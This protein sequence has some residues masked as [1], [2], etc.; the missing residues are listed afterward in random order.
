VDDR[1]P[2]DYNLIFLDDQDATTRSSFL[3]ALESSEGIAA[4]A[5]FDES[6]VPVVVDGVEMASSLAL[7]SVASASLADVWRDDDPILLTPGTVVAP[8]WVLDSLAVVDGATVTLELGDT[9]QTVTLVQDN[10]VAAAVTHPETF[11]SADAGRPAMA[12]LRFTDDADRDS[13]ID[14][15]FALADERGIVLQSID[16]SDYRDTLESTL[17][18]MLLV[19]VGLLAVAVVIALIGVSNTLSLSVF[20]RTRESALLRALGFTR[21]QLRRSLAIEGV[22]LAAVGAS[23][24]IL[25]GVAYGWVGTF[26]LVGDAMQ[27]RVAVPWA[28]V[29]LIVVVALGCG[30]LASVLPARRAVEADP[31]VALADR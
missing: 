30:L 28:S 14:A 18:T 4:V 31:V 6:E 2:I 19:V 12:W 22:L 23:I 25:L 29:G 8:S 20:E 17:N 21:H 10:R 15:A 5:T 3:S 26:T 11:G 27:P 16:V 9:T 24:G 13:T 1:A 7:Q